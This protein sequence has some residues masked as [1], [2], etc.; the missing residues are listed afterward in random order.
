[1]RISSAA[2]LLVSALAL[3]AC[4]QEPAQAPEAAPSAEPAPV[5]AGVDLTQPV[6]VLGT[7]PFWGLD[8][9][10]AGLVYSGLDRPEQRADNGG[11]DIL[12]TSASW[13]ETTDAG[14]ELKVDLFATEC[15]DGMSDRVYP[16]TARVEI[17]G[18]TLAGCA[19]STSAVMSA[20]ESGPV[21]GQPAG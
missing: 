10:P 21:V 19:A 4:S 8:I 6:R 1:M 3:V 16:L 12:G 7:E 11:P 18:E 14:V 20:G 2:F 13:S 15:S 9:T 5:L 17:G